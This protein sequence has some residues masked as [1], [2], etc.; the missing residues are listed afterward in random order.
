MGSCAHTSFA[1]GITRPALV[2]GFLFC[3]VPTMYRVTIYYLSEDDQEGS[4]PLSWRDSNH[5]AKYPSGA[6]RKA[7]TQE[8]G[9]RATLIPC[10]TRYPGNV[11]GEVVQRDESG[12]PELD[13]PIG[14]RIA[15]DVETIEAVKGVH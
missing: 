11:V 12:D 8:F 15:V 13:R 3:V 1:S 2:R 7:V 10:C 14:Q 6:I 9:P 4:L 5:F